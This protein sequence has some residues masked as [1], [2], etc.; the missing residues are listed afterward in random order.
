MKFHIQ[1]IFHQLIYYKKQYLIIWT[2]LLIGITAFTVCCNMFLTSR[3]IQR[4]Y[5]RSMSGESMMVQYDWLGNFGD[6]A[7]YSN[8][9]V[10]VDYRQYRSVEEEFGVELE[11]SY[12]AWLYFSAFMGEE[13]QEVES[14]T[15]VFMND[16]CFADLFGEKRLPDTA[17]VGENAAQAL[18]RLQGYQDTGGEA[19]VDTFGTDEEFQIRKDTISVKG[20]TAGCMDMPKTSAKELLTPWLDSYAEEEERIWLA[21]CV[22]LPVEWMEPL[23]LTLEHTVCHSALQV[24]NREGVNSLTLLKQLTDRLS[25]MNPEFAFRIGDGYLEM[26]S[27]REEMQERA[28]YW[29]RISAAVLVLVA[30]SLTG[31]LL[32]LLWQRRRSKAVAWLCGSTEQMLELETL[33][34]LGILFAL[35]AVPG[36]VLGWRLII[37]G[38]T[39]IL[40]LDYFP[41]G[42]L[43]VGAALVLI[44]T[45]SYLIARV[46]ERRI[47]Y[48][49]ILKG[50]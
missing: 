43:A 7:S 35:A 46:W 13:Y 3:E 15:V 22:I 45:V 47:S 44:L 19:L 34:E 30:G 18:D 17:Y 9:Y 11:F 29:L 33:A 39:G 25:E 48:L 6:E 5:E 12:A 31:I 21:D 1:R 28:Q 24:E 10:P 14:W 23:D 37:S 2:E 41:S 50:E 27:E 49:Q 40:N 32:V 4:E 36:G 42:N 38:S 20:G 26:E 8:P 16:V